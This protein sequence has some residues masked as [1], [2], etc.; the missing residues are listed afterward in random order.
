MIGEP[1]T[2]LISPEQLVAEVKGIYA[3]L[4][5]SVTCCLKLGR[6]SVCDVMLIDF[7]I[8]GSI[9]RLIVRKAHESTQVQSST[10]NS[11]R[12]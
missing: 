7:G 9:S 10:M 8:L 2:R 4:A 3:G 12:H 6:L 11:G 5:M 1:E